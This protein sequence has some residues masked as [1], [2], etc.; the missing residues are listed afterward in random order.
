MLARVMAPG[1]GGEVTNLTVSPAPVQV[2]PSLADLAVSFPSHLQSPPA[3]GKGVALV[4]VV[5]TSGTPVSGLVS[6]ELSA[7][8]SAGGAATPVGT[9]LGS[10][11]LGPGKSKTF[12]VHY[13]LPL[14]LAAGSY[15]FTATVQPFK[16]FTDPSAANNTATDPA[17]FTLG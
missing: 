16:G 17:P 5:N 1:A 13:Q 3:G 15:H 7:A 11:K 10:V 8:P 14:T 2:G 4:T 12:R 6:I 9:L